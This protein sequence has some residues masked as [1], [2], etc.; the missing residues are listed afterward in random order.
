MIKKCRACKREIAKDQKSCYICGAQ[1]SFIGY[2][3]KTALVV[4]VLV[5]SCAAAGYWYLDKNIQEIKLAK[6]QASESQ[7]ETIQLKIEQLEN[8]LLQSNQKIL[9]SETN[10]TIVNQQNSELKTQLEQA[11]QKITEAEN[12]AIEAEKKSGW[13]L[14]LNR[15]L[16]EEINALSAKAPAAEH[17]ALAV[18]DKEEITPKP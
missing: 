2:H 14:K 10:L 12:K 18:D 7:S 1:Q 5:A 16:K 6:V 3:Q 17:E 8:Q 9:D 11:L 13:V 15:Q 4:L